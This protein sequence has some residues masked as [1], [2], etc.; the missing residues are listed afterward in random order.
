MTAAM[1]PRTRHKHCSLPASRAEPSTAPRS[2]SFF[3][4]A[5]GPVDS[6]ARARRSLAA[7]VQNVAR[8]KMD[9]LL[10]MSY[11][12]SLPGLS[13]VGDGDLVIQQRCV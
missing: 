8:M 1:Q 4:V 5:R 12:S 11:S 7:R 6:R 13:F 10:A 3:L 2:D 9:G